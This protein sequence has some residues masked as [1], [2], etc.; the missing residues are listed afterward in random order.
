MHLAQCLFLVMAFLPLVNA[1]APAD[2]LKQSLSAG[3][4]YGVGIG[5]FTPDVSK[6]PGYDLNYAFHLRPWV[7]F[8]AGLDQIIRPIGTYTTLNNGIPSSTDTKDQ[9]YLLPL[10]VHFYWSPPQTHVRLSAG[11]GAA[12]LNH[13]FGAP[14]PYQFTDVSA[15]GAQAVVS[16][17]VALTDS[18]R[19]RLGI[20]A[21]Y[22]YV[23]E[24]TEVTTRILTV[25]PEFTFS[26]R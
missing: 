9:L 24:N 23:K 4:I 11:G 14:I 13:H 21:H 25:G 19:Y 26:F 3:F 2:D 7:A 5:T 6:A 15:F 10:G 22:F 17:D 8:E 20:T 1:Q 12:Y 18:G 16:A